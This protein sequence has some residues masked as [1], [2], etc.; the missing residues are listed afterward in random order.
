MVGCANPL[1]LPD[2][3][4]T[5]GAPGRQ[6]GGLSMGD[7]G[8]LLAV[9]WEEL[10]H[11]YLRTCDSGAVGDYGAGGMGTDCT[12]IGDWGS[13]V[14]VD[15]GS[16]NHLYSSP[17]VAIDADGDIFVTYEDENSMGGI[18][19]RVSPICD[20]SK[21]LQGSAWQLVDNSVGDER[22]GDHGLI[23]SRA[24]VLEETLSADRVIV[25]YTRDNGGGVFEG[26]SSRIDIVAL[27][28]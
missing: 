11:I 13:P 16:A 6:V 5:C 9:V 23:G 14:A 3:E 20:A 15:Q 8:G 4:S 18:R 17:Q 12:N 26:L 24:L 27:C 1:H 19:I 10:A 28:L 25:A 22:F 7:G 21:A 2:P